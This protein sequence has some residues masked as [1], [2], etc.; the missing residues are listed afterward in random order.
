VKDEYAVCRSGKLLEGHMELRGHSCAS[1]AEAVT[2]ERVRNRSGKRCSRQM[3]SYLKTGK[4]KS[5]EPD[6]AKAIETVLN[7]LEGTLFNV[8]PKSRDK[9]E[10][11]E[12]QAA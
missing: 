3:I 1:L 9:R 2:I 8:L 11:T 5:C 7:V 12:G 4:L 6:L 10:V